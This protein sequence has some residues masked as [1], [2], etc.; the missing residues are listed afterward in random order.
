RRS[1]LGARL[2]RRE[3]PGGARTGD[4]AARLQRRASRRA[5]RRQGRLRLAASRVHTEERRDRR[6]SHLARVPLSPRHRR[7]RRRPP[8]GHACHHSFEE[9]C[10]EGHSVMTTEPAAAPELAEPAK[11]EALVHVFALR[12]VFSGAASPALSDVSF[13]IRPGVVTGLVGPDGAGKTTLLRIL[14]GLLLPTSGTVRVLD[15]DP[16]HDVDRLRDL[17]GYMPQKFGLYEDLT[18]EENLQLHAELKGLHGRERSETFARLLEFTSL[19]P[20]TGRLAGNLSG[21]MKQKLGLAC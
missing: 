14:A 15:H 7:P 3:G 1:R 8:A 13:D 19:A 17:L 21:G 9:R 20:F 18:V 4:V 10:Q 12:K 11:K 5:L 6:A 2:R 16:A